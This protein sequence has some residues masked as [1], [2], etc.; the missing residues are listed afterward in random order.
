VHYQ[1]VREAWA[2]RRST[3]KPGSSR[4][5]IDPITGDTWLLVWS[6]WSWRR[7][8]STPANPSATA[9]MHCVDVARLQVKI[10][11]GA[12]YPTVTLEGNV[13]RTCAAH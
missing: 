13:Q 3:G 2:E 10:A 6:G 4:P 7:T 8:S 11:E 1:Q 5:G 12:L 9:A